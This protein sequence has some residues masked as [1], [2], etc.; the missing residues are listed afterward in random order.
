M[1]HEVRPRSTLTIL[2]NI[3]RKKSIR[4]VK[5]KLAKR[6]GVTDARKNSKSKALVSD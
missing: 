5:I 6:V 3:R 4:F 2:K 1:Q